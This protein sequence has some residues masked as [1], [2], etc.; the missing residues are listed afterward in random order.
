MLQ[1]EVLELQ[2][3]VGPAIRDSH[4]KLQTNGRLCKRCRKRL[5]EAPSHPVGRSVLTTSLREEPGSL[6]QEKGGPVTSKQV[7]KHNWL[8]RPRMTV[9]QDQPGHI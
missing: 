5:V 4:H 1:I 9:A 7:P 8:A 2:N 6:R 3:Y